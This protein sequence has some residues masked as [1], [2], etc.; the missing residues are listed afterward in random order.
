MERAQ[1]RCAPR[2]GCYI[3]RRSMGPQA[4]SRSCRGLSDENT[5]PVLASNTQTSC[6]SISFASFSSSSRSL[7]LFNLLI[8]VHELGHFLAAR[9]RGWL[10][11]S[12]ASGL[13]NR[14]GR[15]RSTAWN[16]VRL[17]PFGGF[18][19]L[20]QLAPM[21]MIEG[22]VDRTGRRSRRSPRWIRS[23]SRSPG[24]FSAS[25]RVFFRLRRLGRRPSGERIGPD[26]GDRVRAAGFARGEA[27]FAAG[28]KIV[29]VDGQP[30]TRFV[31]MSGQRRLAKWSAAKG[32]TI[33]TSKIERRRQDQRRCRSMGLCR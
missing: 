12:S 26:D 33:P 11:R 16:T 18:V 27:G 28:D 9:W 2:P 15:R 22:K 24:R 14:S 25:A 3:A 5:N 4:S 13:A 7:L 8:V 20:P 6:S 23:S 19:A 31:G 21:D 30:V 17:I 32:A 29:G 1:S 10:S